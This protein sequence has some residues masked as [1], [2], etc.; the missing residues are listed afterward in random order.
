L[1]SKH[2]RDILFATPELLWDAA[3]EYFE[4]TSERKWEKK[5]WVGKDAMEVIRET[6]TPFTLAGLCLYIGCSRSYFTNFKKIC[7]EDFLT[8]IT[9]I[10]DIIFTQKFEGAAVGAYNANIIARDLGLVDKTELKG[11]IKTQKQDLTELT[12]E[13]LNNLAIAVEKL[14]NNAH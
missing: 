3:K 4:Y 9:R 8:V 6:D 2:G 5:D 12:D 1:R 14:N 10:E 13:E 7:S 11:D